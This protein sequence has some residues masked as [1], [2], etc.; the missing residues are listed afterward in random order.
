MLEKSARAG[1]GGIGQAPG[2]MTAA[3]IGVGSWVNIT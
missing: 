3:V 1:R 2:T